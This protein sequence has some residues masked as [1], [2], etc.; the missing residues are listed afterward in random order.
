MGHTRKSWIPTRTRHL[1]GYGDDRS[2]EIRRISGA[3]QLVI[4]DL[5]PIP[6]LCETQHG[7]HEIGAK[8]GIDP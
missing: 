6:L 2:G 5:E 7:S 4:D 3:P 1:T 8:R